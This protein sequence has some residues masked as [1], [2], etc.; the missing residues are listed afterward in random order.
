MDG[1]S[2]RIGIRTNSNVNEDHL[3]KHIYLSWISPIQATA[4]KVE[5]EVETTNLQVC[6]FLPPSIRQNPQNKVRKINYNLYL[7]VSIKNIS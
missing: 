1:L 4:Q 5:T 3:E 6:G 7:F 2:E